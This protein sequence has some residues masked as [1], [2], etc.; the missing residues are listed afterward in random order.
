MRSPVQVWSA[1]PLKNT[2]FRVC[3]FNAFLTHLRDLFLNRAWSLSSALGD[4][5]YFVLSSPSLAVSSSITTNEFRSRIFH[6]ILQ[7][8]EM[9]GLQPCGALVACGRRLFLQAISPPFLV[10]SSSTKKHTVSGVT[11][12]ET[13]VGEKLT[14]VFL[15]FTVTLFRLRGLEIL[16]LFFCIR[17]QFLPFQKQ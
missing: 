8:N 7:W 17:F 3:F 14:P 9:H 15:S 12:R 10:V 6:F 11:I 5:E 4:W 16:L 13:G 2:P 1:A